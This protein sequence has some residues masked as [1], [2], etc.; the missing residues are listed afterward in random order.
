MSRV[1]FR[2]VSLFVGWLILLASCQPVGAD[3]LSGT[4]GEASLTA[5]LLLNSPIRSSSAGG[6]GVPQNRADASTSKPT[7]MSAQK[8]TELKPIRPALPVE[9]APARPLDVGEAQATASI[10]WLVGLAMRQLPP[11]YS[12]DKDW[13]KT[14]SIWSGVDFRRD[15]LKLT[16]KRRRKDVRHGRWTKYELKLPPEGSGNRPQ[17]D[18]VSVTKLPSGVWQIETVVTLPLDFDARI[19]RW[20][21]GVKWYSVS[22]TGKMRVRLHTVATLNMLADY[23]ELPPA[24]VVDP[25]I[26]QAHATLEYF[27]V[28]RVS[29]IGGDVAEEFGDAVEK[30]LRD[31]WLKK[32]NDRLVAKLQKAIDKK[33]DDLRWSSAEWFANWQSP[34]P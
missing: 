20:N 23:S 26:V 22:V 27:E 31:V 16:T 25:N 5:P 2:T 13:G 34:A 19:E 30:I 11:T 4:P 9:L 14:K 17:A 18:V 10:R 24:L 8:S 32:E 15:G 33:R 21:L 7:T 3:D 6:S 29:K 12:G 28:E 1:S